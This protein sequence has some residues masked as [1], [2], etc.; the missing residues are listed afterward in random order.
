[1]NSPYQEIYDI[2]GEPDISDIERVSS[3]FESK[4]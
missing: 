1:M 4:P 2:Y 3:K